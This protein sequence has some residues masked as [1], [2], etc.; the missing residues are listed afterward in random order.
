MISRKPDGDTVFD[1]LNTL[2]FGCWRP[3]REG[4]LEVF[5]HFPGSVEESMHTK[6]S[7]EFSS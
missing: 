5:L 7:A 3:Q 4:L 6:N 1:R 2:L